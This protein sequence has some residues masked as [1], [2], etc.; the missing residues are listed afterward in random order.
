MDEQK[1]SEK[2]TPTIGSQGNPAPVGATVR[3][4][5]ERGD[6]Y[7]AP[8][9][10]N[11]DITLREIVKGTEASNRIAEHGL[12]GRP[13]PGSDYI[14]CRVRVGYFS[15]GR[16]FGHSTEK[17]QVTG[18]HFAAVAA[19]GKEE[20]PLP[21][22]LRQ[23]DPPLVG[24]SLSVNESREGWVVLQVPAVGNPFLIFRREY[25][26]NQYGVWGPVWFRMSYEEV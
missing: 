10:Y 20:F 22:L 8:E 3:T 24:T 19:D 11:L 23:P 18:E 4:R 16:G 1:A 25:A 2:K 13:E 12:L 21:M 9:V 5:V 6:R 7:S 26:T 14:L 15:K 17:Y